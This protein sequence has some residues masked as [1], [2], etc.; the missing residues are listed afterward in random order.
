MSTH[1]AVFHFA[2]RTSL[3]EQQ[4]F[5]LTPTKMSLSE[6]WQGE[7]FT[8]YR[9]MHLEGRGSECFPCRGCSAW[10]AGIRDWD[11]GWLKVLK[12]TGEHLKKVMSED[13][14][15][16]VEIFTPPAAAS[17]ETST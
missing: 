5:S 16:E 3:F 4:N 2:V 1:W 14:G 7:V 10:K 6:I 9:K 17:I 13:L 11:H 15:A 12:K 8:W